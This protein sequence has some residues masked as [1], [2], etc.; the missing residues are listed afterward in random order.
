MQTPDG[1]TT[2]DPGDLSHGL[3]VAL[4][5]Q[6]HPAG[7]L[8]DID[9][10]EASMGDEAGRFFAVMSEPVDGDPG[11]VRLVVVKVGRDVTG[12]H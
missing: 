3:L 12:L 10:L 7:A 9:R 6:H 4:L 8:L 5:Q 11:R 1:M 2:L